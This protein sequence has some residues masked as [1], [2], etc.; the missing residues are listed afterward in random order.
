MSDFEIGKVYRQRNG[1]LVKL[2][3]YDRTRED[4]HFDGPEGCARAVRVSDGLPLGPRILANGRVNCWDSTDRAGDLVAEHV[5]LK[6]SDCKPSATPT[7]EQW[8]A[9]VNPEV[10]AERR[11]NAAMIAR[12]GP[13]LVKRV[14]HPA[15]AAPVSTALPPLSALTLTPDLSDTSHQV[16]P[17]FGSA[18][19][20]ERAI[21]RQLLR[22][23][24]VPA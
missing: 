2:I 1:D 3:A 11:A 8:A 22:D 14:A 6:L 10:Q 20:A 4:L 21:E 16:R 13:Q 9:F 12:D 19:R 7:R 18:W 15:P 5:G 17:D 23:L 24:R